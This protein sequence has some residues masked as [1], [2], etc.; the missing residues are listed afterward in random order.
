MFQVDAFLNIDRDP[1]RKRRKHTRRHLSKIYLESWMAAAE[2][3]GAAT[4][5]AVRQL[6]QEVTEVKMAC[7]TPRLDQSLQNPREETAEIG[8]LKR[9]FIESGVELTNHR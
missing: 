1:A 7:E 2:E 9:T 5:R 6:Q 8:S 3:R 4:E